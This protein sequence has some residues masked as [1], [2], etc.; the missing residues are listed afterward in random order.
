MRRSAGEEASGPR[1]G[2][3]T[4]LGID[5]AGRG[6]LIGPLVVG[7]FLAPADAGARLREIGVRDSKLLSPVRRDEI[8][9]RLP[10]LGRC[11]SVRASPPQVDAQVRHGFLN[12]LEA[13]LFA[14]LIVIAQPDRVVADACDP[15]EKRFGAELRKRARV[16]VPIDAH[17]HADLDDPM[18]GAA[19]IVAKV[20]RDRAVA[21]LRARLGGEIGSGYPSDARTIAFVRSAISGGRPAGTWLRKSWRTTERLILEHRAPT[22]ES[23]SK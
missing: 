2:S 4:V 1:H 15:N 11:L 12:H 17:H 22:L 16:D 23:F 3:G 6:S 7:G 9:R 5:E 21:R 19:S 18:V 20:L 14:Q 13:K 10:E 8:F